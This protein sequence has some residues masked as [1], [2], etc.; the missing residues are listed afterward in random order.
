MP[1]IRDRNKIKKFYNI[2]SQKN[3]TFDP[4]ITAFNKKLTIISAYF[5]IKKPCFSIQI[6]A[7]SKL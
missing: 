2:P 1:D 4:S 5:S 6:Q 3:F 7:L